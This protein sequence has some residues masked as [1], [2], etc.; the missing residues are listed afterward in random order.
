M[1]YPSAVRFAFIVLAAVLSFMAP[2]CNQFDTGS[3]AQA[4]A[5]RILECPQSQVEITAVGA[6]RYRGEGCGQH[7]VLTCTASRLEP[8]CLRVADLVSSGGEEDDDDALPTPD[9][10]AD[11][12]IETLIR[13]GLEARRDDVLACAGTQR[14]AIRAAYAPDGS[15]DLTAQGALSDT[16]EE[17]C[18]QDA[19]DG[20]RVPAT[21]GAGVVVH[22]VR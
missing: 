16:A 21:G 13:A 6:Y 17:R 4:S 2:G 15:V 12:E 22:L 11:E 10:E 14:V 5:A 1:R 3:A 19:L 7:V 8:E 18:I 20:V 9:T